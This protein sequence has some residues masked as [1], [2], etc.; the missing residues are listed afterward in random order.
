MSDTSMSDTSMSGT[1]TSGT[2]ISDTSTDTRDKN[3]MLP[4]AGED[5]KTKSLAVGTDP[6]TWD[7]IKK[8]F[9]LNSSKMNLT[10]GAF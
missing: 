5:I 4:R 3:K 7:T 8:H 6:L 1:S 9:L 10:G 2:S